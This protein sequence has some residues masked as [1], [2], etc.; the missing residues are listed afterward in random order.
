MPKKHENKSWEA[1]F[2]SL[3]GV[4]IACRFQAMGC[5]VIGGGSGDLSFRI[6]GMLDYAHEMKLLIK[7]VSDFSPKA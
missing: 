6:L 4:Y 1:E 5:R 3:A 2:L 7:E